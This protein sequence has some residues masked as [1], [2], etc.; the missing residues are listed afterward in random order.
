MSL[1]KDTKNYIYFFRFILLGFFL[2]IF[3]SSVFM[4]GAI[5]SCKNGNGILTG[6]TC[7][8]FENISVCEFNGEYYNAEVN[9]QL[10]GINDI[11]NINVSN[12]TAD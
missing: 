10:I 5:I 9:N 8:N 4:L 7:T 1:I 12:I 2:I 6:L 11:I 3:I